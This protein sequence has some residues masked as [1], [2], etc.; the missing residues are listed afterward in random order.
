MKIT[1]MLKRQPWRNIVSK[2]EINFK[3]LFQDTEEM[4]K[5]KNHSC[6]SYSYHYSIILYI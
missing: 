1:K 6:I 3:M 4:G 5:W 2:C